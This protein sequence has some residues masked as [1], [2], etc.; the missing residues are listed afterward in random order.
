MGA[1]RL[2]TIPFSHFCEKARWALERAGL[3]FVEDASLPLLHWR[4]SYG[5]G[6]GRTVPVLVTD[7]DDVIPDSTDILRFADARGARLDTDNADV[8]ALEERFDVELGPHTRRL[9]Y[10]HLLP[11]GRALLR[12]VSAAVPSWQNA[13]VRFSFPVA[14]TLMKRGMRIDADTAKRSRDK[15]DKV[16][17]HVDDLLRFRPFIA[18]DA[19]TAADLTFAALSA[20]I[21]YPAE[22]PHSLSVS[23]LPPGLAEVQ[24]ALS[25]TKAGQHALRL[26]REQRRVVASRN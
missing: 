24:R 22:Q 26:Y 3:S 4:A 7:D 25:S 17:A 10:Y 8:A 15:I 1:M 23:E 6:G 21:L 5:A 20:P 19:F 2:V 18:G 16:F 11:N 12:A 14:R 9:A 13:V